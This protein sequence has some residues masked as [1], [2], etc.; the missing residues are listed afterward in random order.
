MANDY[1]YTEAD[2]E[3]VLHFL[4]TN[5]PKVATPENAVK[6]LVYMNEQ[7]KELESM[8]PEEFERL[9]EGLQED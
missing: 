8:S 9:L 2:V 5:F 3:V 1:K 7:T 6:V 4:A